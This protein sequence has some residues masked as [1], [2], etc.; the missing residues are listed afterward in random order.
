MPKH[1]GG[2]PKKPF[3]WDLVDSLLMRE[4]SLEFVAERLIV[5]DG[6]FVNK[7]SIDAKVK[8]IQRRI[9]E[10]FSLSFVQYRNQKMEPQRIKLRDWQWKA[11]EKGSIPMLI[12]LGKQYLAQSERVEQKTEIGFSETNEI[13]ERFDEL[14]DKVINES[15]VVA[16][17][18]PIKKI[19]E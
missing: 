6:A 5:K 4:S 18:E 2:A 8:L 1:P 14:K 16:V 13:R 12:W 9:K 17:I 7:K 10:R 19:N 15:K 11:A 3:D